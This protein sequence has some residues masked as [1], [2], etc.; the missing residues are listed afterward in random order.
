VRL[1][2]WLFRLELTLALA[3]GALSDLWA[4]RVVARLERISSPRKD[5]DH[6]G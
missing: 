5:S 6:A 3:L 1:L 4:A 2:R